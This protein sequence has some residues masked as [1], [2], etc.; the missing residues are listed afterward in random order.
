MIKGFKGLNTYNVFLLVGT[1]NN[2]YYNILYTY[3]NM[4]LI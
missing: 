1:V 4:L 3:Y 2:Y